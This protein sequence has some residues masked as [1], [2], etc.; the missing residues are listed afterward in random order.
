[1]KA[2]ILAA[3]MGTRLRPIT[4]SLPKCLVP[5]NSKPI[6][7]HQLDALLLAGIREV[8]LVV[9]HLGK[10][11]SDNYGTSYHDSTWIARCCCWRVTWFLNP[12]CYID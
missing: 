12:N 7:E 4:M 2:I 5:V 10:S 11:L 3:G 6:L 9:G 1:M 8:V